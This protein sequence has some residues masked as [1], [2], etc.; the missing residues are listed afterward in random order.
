MNESDLLLG[1]VELTG[2]FTK[3][4]EKRVNADTYQQGWI[5]W[6][7]KSNGK[8]ACRFR[9]WVRDENKPGEWRKAATPWE[10]GLTEKQAKKRLRDLMTAMEH[11]APKPPQVVVAKKDG[12]TSLKGVRVAIPGELTTAFLTLRLYD[13]AVQYVVMPFDKIMQVWQWDKCWG[14]DFPMTAMAA[15]R[16]GRGEDAVRA[17]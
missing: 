1:S 11:E 3:R 7:T 15:A 12:P 13:P 4:K 6:K 16:L 5:E 2:A 14:W 8:K 9:Y 17:L 10:E